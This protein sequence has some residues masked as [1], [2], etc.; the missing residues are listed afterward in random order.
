M[1]LLYLL[2]I[3]TVRGVFL[4]TKKYNN[5]IGVVLLYLV[6]RASYLY[7]WIMVLAFIL[8]VTFDGQNYAEEQ[9]MIF[10]SAYQCTSYAEILNWQKTSPKDSLRK[11]S[12]VRAYCLP[13][14]VPSD[15]EFQD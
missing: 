12:P 9:D 7:H 14:W 3:F 2:Y 1:Y 4:G 10:R 13:K 8:I 6:Q 5:P 15:S 11:E